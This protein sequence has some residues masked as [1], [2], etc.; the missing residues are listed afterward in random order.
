MR[1][2]REIGQDIA[3][4]RNRLSSVFT[5]FAN[6]LAGTLFHSMEPWCSTDTT[7]KVANSYDAPAIT[8][9]CSIGDVA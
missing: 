9:K 2:P 3:D 1:S 7:L 6:R 8:V 5:F 4:S